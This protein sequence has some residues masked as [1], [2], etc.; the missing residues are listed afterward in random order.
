MAYKQHAKS[1]EILEDRIVTTLH[2]AQRH[3]C[4]VPLS[5][6]NL[7]ETCIITSYDNSDYQMYRYAYDLVKEIDQTQ[8][9]TGD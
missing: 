3:G 4:Q 8:K 5:S 6:K 1:G 7:S 2:V 9:N